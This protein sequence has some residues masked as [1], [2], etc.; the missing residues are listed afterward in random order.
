MGL[1]NGRKKVATICSGLQWIRV[2]LVGGR[3]TAGRYRGIIDQRQM[4]HACEV[5]EKL[6][7]RDFDALIGV[8]EGVGLDAK[9]RPYVFDTTK[10][11]LELAKDVSALAN[12]VGGIIVLGFDTAREPLT[13]GER[14]SEVRPFPVNMVDPDRYRKIV[15]EYVYPPLDIAVTVFEAA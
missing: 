4:N 13:A 10:Q 15:H 14:I 3:N 11:R 1:A 9:D 2:Q 7:A 5:L 8:A 12:A 6:T